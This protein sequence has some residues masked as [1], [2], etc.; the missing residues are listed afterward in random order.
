MAVMTKDQAYLA[1]HA[2]WL[3]ELA[4]REKLEKALADR[5]KLVK[6]LHDFAKAGER[7]TSLHRGKAWKLLREL[8]EVK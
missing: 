5:E 1:L 3:K 7:E 4:N 8:G 6:A 2:D